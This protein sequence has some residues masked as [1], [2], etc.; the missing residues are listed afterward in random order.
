MSCVLDHVISI[1]GLEDNIYW[2]C[3]SLSNDANKPSSDEGKV[4]I[5][6]HL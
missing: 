4:Y 3:P 1:S 2:L 6:N 5:K